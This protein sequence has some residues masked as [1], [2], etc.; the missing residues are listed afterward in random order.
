MTKTKKFPPPG[1][2]AVADGQRGGGGPETAAGRGP[3]EESERGERPEGGQ[4]LPRAGEDSAA[5]G[6]Q[7]A[8][9]QTRAT[10][11]GG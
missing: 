5:G 7:G 3:G 4:Q 10:D 11:Q 1:E 2:G 6:E 9:S 8:A